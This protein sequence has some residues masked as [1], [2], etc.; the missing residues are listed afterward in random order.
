MLPL[1]KRTTDNLVAVVGEK[2]AAQES[3]EVLRYNNYYHNLHYI[4]VTIVTTN[5]MHGLAVF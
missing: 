2:A 5:Y 4:L 1:L 3:F